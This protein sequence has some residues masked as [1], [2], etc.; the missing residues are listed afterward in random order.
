MAAAN[1]QDLE[2]TR[3]D[4]GE[5]DIQ[6]LGIASIVGATFRFFVKAQ[7]SDADSAAVIKK[8]NGVLT[9]IVVTDAGAQ[10]LRLT[11]DPA[12]TL[13]IAAETSFY[14]DFQ[15][16]EASGKVRTLTEGRFKVTIDVTQTA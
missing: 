13:A 10:I 1:I 5:W 7:K 4:T 15:I 11:V 8:D 16:T 2:L 12:N 9:G 14:W 6:V 3:G